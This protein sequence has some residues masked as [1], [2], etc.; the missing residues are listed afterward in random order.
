MRCKICDN[1]MDK[2]T[3]NRQL[4]DWE[5]CG[6]CLEVIFNVFEDAPEQTSEDE[7]VEDVAE[8]DLVRFSLTGQ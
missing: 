1:H 3:W 2:P 4:N 6:D 7:E 5:V 8:E